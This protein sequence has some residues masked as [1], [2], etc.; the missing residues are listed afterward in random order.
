M[1]RKHSFR[2]GS[3]WQK[4]LGH[5]KKTVKET[6]QQLNDVALNAALD[7]SFLKD[8]MN[9]AWGRTRAKNVETAIRYVTLMMN[10]FSRLTLKDNPYS[11]HSLPTGILC[12]SQLCLRSIGTANI[13]LSDFA[14]L[15]FSNSQ[16]NM[17]KIEDGADDR[18]IRVLDRCKGARSSKK[19]KN[20]QLIMFV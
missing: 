5:L 16:K 14:L 15:R 10:S 3:E 20:N 7:S 8:V 11:L 4:F 2:L 9:A 18:Y 19:V 6:S 1:S 12:G 13:L 17:H